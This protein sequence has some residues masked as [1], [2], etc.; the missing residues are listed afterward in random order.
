M[1]PRRQLEDAAKQ[2]QRRRRDDE[3]QVVPEGGPIHFRRHVRVREQRADLRREQPL[4]ARGPGEVHRLDADAVANQVQHRPARIARV[5]DADGEHAVEPLHAIDAPLLVGVQQHFGVGVVRAPLVFAERLQLLPDL[6]VVVDLAVE[7]QGDGA[8]GVQ[9]RLGRGVR[10]IDDRQPPMAE[11]RRSSDVHR[12]APSG[13]RCAMRSRMRATM[14]PRASG[15][16]PPVPFLPRRKASYDAARGGIRR[17]ALGL[18]RRVAAALEVV[19]RLSCRRRVAPR[20]GAR[21]YAAI[22]PHP[23]RNLAHTFRLQVGEHSVPRLDGVVEPQDAFL[24]LHDQ[25]LGADECAAVFE[26]EIGSMRAVLLDILVH[27]P[28][29]QPFSWGLASTGLPYAIITSSRMVGLAILRQ[30][31]V[32]SRP[33]ST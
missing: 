21:W 3:G 29:G 8:G 28:P 5:V 6:R 13:P 14:P 18:R 15:P 33:R 27:G 30:W 1:W 22:S 11:H 24:L 10:Q 31:L 7:G 2:R 23:R 4:A 32:T 26:T 20:R 16:G 25:Q 12:P 17:S 19:R 9:H